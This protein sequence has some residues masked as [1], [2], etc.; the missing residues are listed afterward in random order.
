M[1]SREGKKSP[2]V[3][4]Q[5]DKQ[6]VACP[7]HETVLSLKENGILAQ[8]TTWMNREDTEW[9]ERSQVQKDYMIPLKWSTQCRQIHRHRKDDHS[10]QG[11]GTVGKGSE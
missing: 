6:N 7:D 2:S 1:E 5:T 8:A 11:L 10:G 3:H 4:Q 9:G